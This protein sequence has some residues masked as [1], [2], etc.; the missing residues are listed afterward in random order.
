MGGQWSMGTPIS[1]TKSKLPCKQY[2]ALNKFTAQ[3]LGLIKCSCQRWCLISKSVRQ[4]H[5]QRWL[6]QQLL[7]MMYQLH[8]M[9]WGPTE[10]PEV[11]ELR[12]HS[13]RELCTVV[14]QITR[15]RG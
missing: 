11:V 4:H 7:Q 2:H 3:R 10:P 13:V 5:R 1:P 9:R 12:K 15:D 14:Y 6:Q 8:E